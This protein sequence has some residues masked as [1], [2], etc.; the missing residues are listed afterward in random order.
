MPTTAGPGSPW[1]WKWKWLPSTA[2]TS[3]PGRTR[4]RRGTRSTR[5]GIS[6]RGA[7]LTRAASDRDPAGPTAIRG[8]R[9][10]FG[11][12]APEA[13]LLPIRPELTRG[14]NH[15]HEL[16]GRPAVGCDAGTTAGAGSRIM[17]LVQPCGGRRRHLP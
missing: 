3:L 14:R 6:A 9:V 7:G 17:G 8:T 13:V 4:R 10:L 1:N 12:P 11:R 5:T 16:R 2:R 15:A